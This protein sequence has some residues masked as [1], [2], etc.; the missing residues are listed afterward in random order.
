MTGRE[1][2]FTALIIIIIMEICKAPA[3]WLK[4]LN[5]HSITYIMYME[6]ERS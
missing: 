3:L 6:M 1:N 2:K 5:R 4:A